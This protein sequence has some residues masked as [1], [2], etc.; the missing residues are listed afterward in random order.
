MKKVIIG[1]LIIIVLWTLL[2]LIIGIG[3]HKAITFLFVVDQTKG[4]LIGGTI[5]VGVYYLKMVR[6][7]KKIE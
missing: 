1:V 5:V 3:N 4:A 6:D 7:R 2:N